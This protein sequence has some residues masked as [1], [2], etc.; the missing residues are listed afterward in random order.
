MFKIK[1]SP[2]GPL[3]QKCLT[4]NAVALKL[5]FESIIDFENTRTILFTLMGIISYIIHFWKTLSTLSVLYDI[6]SYG[7]IWFSIFPNKIFF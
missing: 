6:V 5:N 7:V 4:F 2:S 3:K 1:L